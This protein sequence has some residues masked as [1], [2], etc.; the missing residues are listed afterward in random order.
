MEVKSY[1]KIRG[2]IY[3]VT[4]DNGDTHKLYDDIILK[5]ELLID[6]R[7]DQKKL[8]KVLKE[9]EELDA[10]FK[11]IK[12]IG[13]KMRTELEIKKYLRK[14]DIQRSAIEKCILKLKKDGYL[15]QE[16]YVEAF[17]NDA[18]NLGLNGPR[19]IKDNLLKLGIE[20]SIIDKKIN[21][22]DDTIW[23][24]R[25]NAILKKKVKS[26]KAG[27]ALFKKKSYSD[28]ICLGYDLDDI[29]EVLDNYIVDTDDVFKKEA[30]KI[31]NKLAKKYEGITLELQFKSKMFARGFDGDQISSYL[32][33]K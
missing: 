30:D 25:I 17:V 9:N 12:Y 27:L 22:V 19:K 28:L 18:L 10:Y 23:L 32:L 33:D 15:D 20:E 2:N 24:D 29:R 5:Y 13:V 26:N 8:S 11:T 14:Y 21:S 4:L 7:I 6:K 31:Y 1:K 16:R 3:E